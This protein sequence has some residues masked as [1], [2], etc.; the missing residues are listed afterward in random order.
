MLAHIIV[1]VP[2]MQTDQA[3]SYRVPAELEE[4]LKVGVRVH[5]PFGTGNRLIQ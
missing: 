1:D 2:L 3:Y 4:G 5:V